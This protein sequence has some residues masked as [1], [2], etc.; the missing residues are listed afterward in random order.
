MI[1]FFLFRNRINKLIEKA[2]DGNVLFD[3]LSVAAKTAI[4]ES[5]T[6]LSV[7]SGATIIR[8]VSF[9]FFINVKRFQGDTVATKFYVLEEGNCE[10]FKSV[11]GDAKKVHSYGPGK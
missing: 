6:Q 2:V 5:M 10:V 1:G 4:I 7:S 11:N 8:E 3:M 9:P